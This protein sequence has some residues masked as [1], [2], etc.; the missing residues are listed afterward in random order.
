[1]HVVD[2]AF[3]VESEGSRSKDCSFGVVK[4]RNIRAWHD[5]RVVHEH[6]ETIASHVIDEPWVFD[7]QCLHNVQRCSFQDSEVEEI[8]LFLALQ[9]FFFREGSSLMEL[10]VVTRNC[11]NELFLGYRSIH[12]HR[13]DCCIR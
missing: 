4:Q 12:L 9:V 10:V 1:M 3:A 5:V 6:A 11:L 7:E 13:L 8:L 2:L